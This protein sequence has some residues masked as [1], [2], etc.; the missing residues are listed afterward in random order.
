MWH[1][2]VLKDDGTVVAWGQGNHN[3]PPGLTGVKAISATADGT[4]V[5]KA[6][7]TVAEWAGSWAPRK[8]K[9]RLAEGLKEV[10]AI[11]AG[12]DGTFMLNCDGKV[13]HWEPGR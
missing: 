6:D 13:L 11:S 4:V 9:S 10:T 2:V 1:A 8:G 3:I 5:L 12:G 7:G